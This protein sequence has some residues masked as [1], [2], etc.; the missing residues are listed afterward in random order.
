MDRDAAGPLLLT[1]DAVFLCRYS[2]LAILLL[3]TLQEHRLAL[4]SCWINGYSR[5]LCC[6]EQHG[7]RGDSN[8]WDEVF[9]YDPCCT[10]LDEREVGVDSSIGIQ[11]NA[12]SRRIQTNSQLLPSLDPELLEASLGPKLDG[13]LAENNLTLVQVEEDLRLTIR[14]PENRSMAGPASHAFLALVLLRQGRASEAVMEFQKYSSQ[15]FSISGTGAWVGASA[16]GYHMHDVPFSEALV[17]FFRSQGA[18]TIVDFGC[19]LGLYVRDLRNEGFRAGGF[20]GNPATASIT[21]GRCTTLDLSRTFD[22]GTR[23][24]WVLSLEVAEHIPPQFEDAFV[25]NLDLHAC[26]GLVLSWGNQAGE[27]HVN[28]R[29]RAEVEE[30]FGRRGFRSD[31]ARGSHLRNSARLPWL[32]NTVLVLERHPPLESCGD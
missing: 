18:K 21:E 10:R 30:L 19:G 12:G 15:E 24:N 20:D 28:L 4:S 31:A 2:Q 16:K 32:R 14:S 22:L 27:G 9:Q 23:W 8:C 11:E 26:H 1:V 5:E 25:S 6:N 17:G 3:L 29:S 7:P 13:T